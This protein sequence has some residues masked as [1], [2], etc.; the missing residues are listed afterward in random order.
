MVKEDFKWIGT[1][2]DL[3]HLQMDQIF[4]QLPLLMSRNESTENYLFGVVQLFLTCDNYERLA[5]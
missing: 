1:K 4:I 5:F 3:L 2:S